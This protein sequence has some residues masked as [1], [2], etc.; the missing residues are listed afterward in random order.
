[1]KFMYRMNK[2]NLQDMLRLYYKRNMMLLLRQKD[3]LS[4]FFANAPFYERKSTWW[5]SSRGAHITDINI[6][7]LCV[8]K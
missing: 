1:M 6:L 4:Y 7:S 3:V 2:L 8:V 5:N